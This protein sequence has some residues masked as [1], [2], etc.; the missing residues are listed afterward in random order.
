MSTGFAG[1]DAL[2]RMEIWWRKFSQRNRAALCV[3]G[4]VPASCALEDEFN[5]LDKKERD[6]IFNAVKSGGVLCDLVMLGE[7]CV[8]VVA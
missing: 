8:E 1:Q 4:G 3:L 2:G 5:R 7:H 6:A